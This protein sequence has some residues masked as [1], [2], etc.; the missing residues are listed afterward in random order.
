MAEDKKI[1]D[2]PEL[3]REYVI[4]V[5]RGIMRVPYYRKTKRAV[6][7]IKMFLAKHMRVENRDIRKVKLDKYI[8][9]EMWHD[10]IQN[11]P[12]KIKVKVKRINGIVYAELSDIPEV[13][14]FQ[15]EREK[16]QKEQTEKSKETKLEE[17]KEEKTEEEKKEEQEKEKATQEAGLKTQKQEAKK[18]KHTSKQKQPKQSQI[19]RM[20]MQR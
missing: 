2:K 7:E 8:N 20:A 9:Q 4:N 18:E 15:M 1:E 5:R 16:R 6:K 12:T 3:E 10:G 11:P 14:K 19:H 13:I 17:K